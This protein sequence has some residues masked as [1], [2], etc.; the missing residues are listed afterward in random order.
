MISSDKNI[1]T[2]A[3]LVESA[4]HYIGIQSEYVKLDVIEKV[5]R[6]LTVATISFLVLLLAL[7]M[8]TYLSFALAYGLGPHIGM[9][10]SFVLVAGIYLALLVL[11]LLKRR[12]WIEKPLVH[13]LANLFLNN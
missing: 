6:L 8:L 3:Q 11:F 13:F 9:V 2:I 1:E 7:L 12:Q 5:V 10:W 4:K